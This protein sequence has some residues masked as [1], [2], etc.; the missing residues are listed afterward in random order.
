MDDGKPPQ[1]P[2]RVPLSIT[3]NGPP[4]PSAHPFRTAALEGKWSSQCAFS[5]LIKRLRS[6]SALSR[7]ARPR[8]PSLPAIPQCWWNSPAQEKK[9]SNERQGD[10][11]ESEGLGRFPET[12]GPC[13][14]QEGPTQD[15]T[16]KESE[17]VNPEHLV[18]R[19]LRVC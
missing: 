11:Q 19:E 14:L 7:D 3:D 4:D 9:P 10:P 8:S 16:Q 5:L 6:C 15:I 1:Q 18:V 2:P 13:L 12:G 17:S